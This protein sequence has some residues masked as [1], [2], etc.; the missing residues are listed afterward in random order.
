MSIESPKVNSREGAEEPKKS[1]VFSDRGEMIGMATN[2]EE[3][4]ELYRKYREELD[5]A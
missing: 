3:A 1:P 5:A 4:N 2:Q